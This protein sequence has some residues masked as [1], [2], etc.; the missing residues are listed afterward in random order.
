MKLT[1][2][3]PVLIPSRR[4]ASQT[5]QRQSIILTPV[6]ICLKVQ[7]VNLTWAYSLYKV[8]DVHNCPSIWDIPDYEGHPEVQ[9]IFNLNPVELGI[10]ELRHTALRRDRLFDYL[11]SRSHEPHSTSGLSQT[12]W[13][14]Q[15]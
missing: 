14:R 2:A 1:K 11:M 3:Y 15:A 7:E 8:I 6:G 13:Q 5:K 9:A 4:V 12:T 10:A